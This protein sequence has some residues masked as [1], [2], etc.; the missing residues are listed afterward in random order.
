MQTE[1]AAGVQCGDR[2]SW[3]GGTCHVAHPET[4]EKKVKQEEEGN[5]ST[6]KPEHVAERVAGNRV[7]DAVGKQRGE[8]SDYYRSEHCH[9][10]KKDDWA[11]YC[12][13]ACQLS[14]VVSGAGPL[15]QD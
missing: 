2:V 15:T 10:Q 7:P 1:G 5:K 6:N 4:R 8:K 9:K 14:T 12:H 13:R 11:C 3:P